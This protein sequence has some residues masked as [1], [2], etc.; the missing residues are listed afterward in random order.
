MMLD[1]RD[2]EIVRTRAQENRNV[3]DIW[4]CDK[5]WFGYE[6]T[7]NPERLQ[8]P[9]IRRNDKLERA[10]WDEALSLIASKIREFK[11][12]G[13]LAALG[14]N[15]LTVEEN[16]LFQK[17][18]REGAGV[19]HVD[20]RVGTPV[21]SSEEEGLPP[22]MEMSIGETEELSFAILLGL[23][24][25]EEFPV[26]WLRLKQAINRGAKVI[27]IGHYAPEISPH[28][29]DTILHQPGKE[30]EMIEKHL[31]NIPEGKSAI[32]VGR[33][34]LENRNRKSILSKLLSFRQANQNMSLNI[35]EGSG[36][37]MGARFAGMYPKGGKAVRTEDWD[38]LYLAGANLPQFSRSKLKFLVVQDI[39]MTETAQQADVVLP[40]LTY[41]EKDG[42][43]MNI[44]GRFQK[45][46][47]G[48]FIP[49]NLLSDG[50]IFVSI[51]HRL[52]FS[53]VI[54]PL[55]LE[56]I[57]KGRILPVW[58]QS[59]PFSPV[60]E[61]GKLK[62]TFAP[63][64]FDHGVRMCH[65]PHVIE[66]VKE[67]RIRLHPREAINHGYKDGDVITVNGITGKIKFDVKVAEGTLVFPLGFAGIP[68]NILNGTEMEL[69]D[70]K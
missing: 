68:A 46:K 63:A 66:L 69:K 13:K 30:L 67:P 55:F 62:A 44:E 31:K 20:H 51:G 39:F 60:S 38:F 3:N 52:G 32:F 58:P 34:Y 47:P 37:S 61:S 6:Y 50:Q 33:Q 15:P 64:L 1:S 5:G 17:L 24:L 14:G 48:K 23:D 28:L 35:M 43:F 65:N 25:T 27:F 11:S 19:D 4:L 56:K 18:M 9:L 2:G 16:Y 29:A 8:E 42:T 7:S 54:D 26:I 12:N 21:F 45:L 36:N 59:I 53:N 10:S 70:A 40:T 41:V 57:S 49:E 22:G